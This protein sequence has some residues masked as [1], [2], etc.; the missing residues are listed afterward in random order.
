MP[1]EKRAGSVP[2]NGF[3]STQPGTVYADGLRTGAGGVCMFVYGQPYEERILI[4]H[5]ALYCANYT[6]PLKVPD[7]ANVLSQVRELLVQRRS[8]EANRFAITEAEKCGY[9]NLQ[10]TDRPFDASS[11]HPACYLALSTMKADGPARDYLRTL[12]FDTGKVSTQFS[13]NRGTFRRLAF[14]DA[15]SHICAVQVESP[16]DDSVIRVGLVTASEEGHAWERLQMPANMLF[17]VITYVE[18]IAQAC[19]YD[20]AYMGGRGYGVLLTAKVLRGRAP[21]ISQGSI[22]LMGKGSW[23]LFVKVVLGEPFDRCFLDEQMTRFVASPKS[24]DKMLEANHL[25]FSNVMNRSQLRLCIPEQE[26]LLSVEEMLEQQHTNP[27]SGPLIEKMYDMGRFFLMTETGN[28]PPLIGQLNININLQLCSGNATGLWE[29][30]QV[31][32]GFV[33]TQMPDYHEN[34]RKLLNCRGIMMPIHPYPDSGQLTHF[35]YSWPHQYW[36]SC[37]AWVYNEFWNHYLVTGDKTFLKK[38]VIPGLSEIAQFYRDYLLDRDCEGYYIFYPGMSPESMSKQPHSSS[39]A[40]NTT[41]D[42]M[43]CAEVLT[44]LMTAYIEIGMTPA[45]LSQW[46]DI[47]DHLPPLWTDREGG[48]KEWA[49]ADTQEDYNHRCVSHHYALWPAHLVSWEKT[50]ELAR[51]I[52]ISNRKRAQENDSAHGIIHRLFCAI[53]LRDMPDVEHNFR[54]LLEHGFIRKSLMTNHYPH[55]VFFPDLTGAFPALMQEMALYSEIG[56]V[57]LLPA[58]PM[59]LQKG[60]LTGIHLYTFAH[61]RETTWD[62]AEGWIELILVSHRNQAIKLYC[63]HGMGTIQINEDMPA[64]YSG[65]AVLT[66]EEYIPISIRL[67]RQ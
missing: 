33:E 8:D 41:M 59:Y 58:W 9:V 17:D 15:A 48:L 12:D 36:I 1:I 64:A 11:W 65:E 6:E 40:I 61:A 63:G 27:I 2:M 60:R 35:S 54:Q 29:E 43:A 42:I 49:V 25:R 20:P 16:N 39:L 50:P 19:R 7:L 38:H 51:A 52:Q 66:L 57:R 44:N 26:R 46:Q 21:V 10:T 23:C 31:F 13:D 47:L 14:V 28:L 67:S 5:E 4:T 45:G 3:C 18:G 34:A 53:R 24:F 55:A 32:F 62:L 56:I 37:A 22:T 30:M